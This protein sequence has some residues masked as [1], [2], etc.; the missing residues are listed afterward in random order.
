MQRL[1]DNFNLIPN[2]SFPYSGQFARNQDE[3]RTS[4]K[5]E[6]S[7]GRTWRITRKL[8]GTYSRTSVYQYLKWTYLQ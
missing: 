6:F 1:N 7:F 3:G 8:A 2:I 4:N 5:R